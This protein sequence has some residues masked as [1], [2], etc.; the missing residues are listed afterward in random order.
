MRT[1]ATLSGIEPSR[2]FN[3][4]PALPTEA[5][6]PFPLVCFVVTGMLKRLQEFDPANFD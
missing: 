5:V 3:N 1:F 6:G 2:K 4:R